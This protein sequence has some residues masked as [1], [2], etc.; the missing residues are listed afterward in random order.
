MKYSE[1]AKITYG[2][3][4]AAPY[5]RIDTKEQYD[6]MIAFNKRSNFGFYWNDN[7]RH[8]PTFKTERNKNMGEWNPLKIDDFT[9]DVLK[10]YIKHGYGDYKLYNTTFFSCQLSD[11]TVCMTLQEFYD[12]AVDYED[13]L[14]SEK[15]PL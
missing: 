5:G 9:W 12:K 2:I 11:E 15:E 13:N 3:I 6:Y 8:I 4:D 7:D 1:V 14:W 10:V